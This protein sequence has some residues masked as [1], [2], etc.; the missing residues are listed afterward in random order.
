MSDLVGNPE[1]QF[2]HNEA[3]I[4]HKTPSRAIGKVVLREQQQALLRLRFYHEWMKLPVLSSNNGNVPEAYG[5][6]NVHV[7]NQFPIV[8]GDI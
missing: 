8:I 7:S 4:I 1:G 3:L 2:S 5:Y 6:W